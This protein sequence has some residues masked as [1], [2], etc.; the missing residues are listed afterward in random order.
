LNTVTVILRLLAVFCL[1][2]F[3][4][5]TAAAL[6]SKYNFF[7]SLL[8]LV[9]VIVLLRTLSYYFPIPLNL[10]QFE[11]FDPAV[12][13]SNR[14]LRSLGDL[15]LN[16]FLLLWILLFIRRYGKTA[17]W[18]P[19]KINDKAGL[20][21]SAVLLVAIT[22]MFGNIIRSM[23]SDSQISFNVTDFFDLS[24][25]SFVG[26][27]ILGSLALNYFLL[28]DWLSGFL[29]RYSNGK[30]TIQALALTI[31]GLVYLSFTVNSTSAVYHLILLG[32]LLLLLVLLNREYLQLN[33]LPS[34]GRVIFWLFFF[35]VSLTMLLIHEN[36]RKEW[37]ERIGLAEKLNLQTDPSAENL[38]NLA[39]R[40]FRP[41]FLESE[42]YRFTFSSGNQ[43]LKDSLISE[44]FSGYLNKF[45][46]EIYTFTASENPEPLFNID[47]ISFNTLN[48]VYTLQSKPTSGGDW[49]YYE[50][51]FDK[52]YY[53]ARRAVHDKET[54]QVIG[55]VFIISRPKRYA[56]E[57]FNPELFS[58]TFS[59]LPDNMASYAY[60]IY[61][62]KELISAVNDYPFPIHLNSTKNARPPIE[63]K[64]RNGYSELWYTVS[65]DLT[66]VVVKPQNQLLE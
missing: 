33:F 60:A 11:L 1:L 54:N 2:M 45:D 4:Q 35:S 24:T 10:R 65:K 55:Y 47:S 57:K 61:K 56:D 41:E 59:L 12:Y 40:N 39:L 20:I 34:N 28:A 23:V 16:S 38:L 49:Q 63:Q 48:T 53:I 36:S 31:T 43:F 8:F 9:G 44:N 37:Q 6:T 51:S 5:K 64:R 58:R 26:F 32:W 30:L 18:F 62:N 52:F 15:F 50:E 13:G 27:C 14:I 21:I 7:I 22:I 3:I 25:F 66:V 42:F 29:K 17:R 19:V 46:T